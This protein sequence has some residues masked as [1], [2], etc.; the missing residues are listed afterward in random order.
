MRIQT[1]RDDAQIV[2]YDADAMPTP[3]AD[4]FDAAWWRRKN[5]QTGTATG[6]G[7]VA[8][9]R[10]G[11][12]G[13]IWV[14]RN[15][16]RGG[17]VRHFLKRTYLW[18][19]LDLSRPWQEFHLTANLFAAGL[20]VPCPVAARVVRTGPVYHGDL[21]TT[22]IP[23]SAPLAD[24]LASRELAKQEWADI[25]TMIRRFHEA[26]VCHVDINIRNILRDERGGYF[27]IDFDKASIEL[28]GKWEVKTLARFR[29]SLNKSVAQDPKVNFRPADWDALMEGY[30]LSADSP[31]R[32]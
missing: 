20:P 17:F 24:V 14:L 10:G 21:I 29:R 5:L 30:S 9:V 27:L 8:F 12:N 28:P 18:R 4:P 2:L 23:D 7:S 1:W 25:G 13:E 32:R 11:I 22:F 15:Y 19:G 31:R 6:R 16:R 26:G 3:S